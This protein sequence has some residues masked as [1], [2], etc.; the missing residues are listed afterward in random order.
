M[1]WSHVTASCTVAVTFIARWSQHS[2]HTKMQPALNPSQSGRLGAALLWWITATA[3][4]AGRVGQKPPRGARIPGVEP[5][6]YRLCSGGSATTAPRKS[7]ATNREPRVQTR[8]VGSCAAAA[9]GGGTRRPTKLRHRLRRRP[10]R[11]AGSR[12]RLAREW[13]N[14]DSRA[15][16]SVRASLGLDRSSGSSLQAR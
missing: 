10:A 15:L 4:A 1:S 8:W 14:G 13:R 5:K 2:L 12:T 9:V 6:R 3:T 11:V 7:D 16:A